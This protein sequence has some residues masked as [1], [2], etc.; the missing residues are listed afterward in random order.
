VLITYE[1]LRRQIYR[2]RPDADR[3]LRGEKKYEKQRDPFTPILWWRV[4]MDEVQMIQGVNT[5][6]AEM[7]GMLPAINKWGASG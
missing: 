4:V 7:A 5:N 6:A 2:A 1:V 3:R